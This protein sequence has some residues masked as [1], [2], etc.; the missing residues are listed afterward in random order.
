MGRTH[1]GS[2]LMRT[3]PSNRSGDSVVIVCGDVS[4]HQKLSSPA[5]WQAFHLTLVRCSE[6]AASIVSLCQKLTPA[7]LIARQSFIETQPASEFA[8][9]TQ[10]GRGLR[11]LAVLDADAIQGDGI[12][13]V[14]RL[15]RLGCRGVL[16]AH[17]SV[18]LQKR[19]VQCVIDG[20]LWA[21]RS[22]MAAMLTDF[23]SS[24]SSKK[25]STLTPREQHILDLI[26]QGYKNSEIAAFL[27]ISQETVRWHKRRLHRKMARGQGRQL[28]SVELGTSSIAVLE[29]S[30]HKA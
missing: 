15:L 25:E 14:E 19:A 4:P 8:E 26:E 17:L 11:V 18:K 30:V 5:F 29:H 24:Q 9:M 1:T 13:A 6:N 2:E 10:H 28:P 16:P 22:V 21:P 7:L 23:L 27:F 12:R 20:E 3:A